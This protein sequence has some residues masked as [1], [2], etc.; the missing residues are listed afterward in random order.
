[1]FSLHDIDDQISVFIGAAES[2]EAKADATEHPHMKSLLL[3]HACA[4]RECASALCRMIER[5][6]EREAR[7]AMR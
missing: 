3:A 2:I 6:V 5:A 4:L 1:M 7:E